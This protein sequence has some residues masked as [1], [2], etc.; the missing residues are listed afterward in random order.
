MTNASHSAKGRGLKISEI[1]R[2]LSD[3]GLI[4][5]EG[6][7]SVSVEVS[8]ICTDSRK[9]KRGDVF[10]A[11]KGES[12]DSHTTIPSLLQKD[13]KPALVIYS[14]GQFT[15]HFTNDCSSLRVSDTRLAWSLLCALECEFAKTNLEFYGVTGTNGKTS[16]VF[17]LNHFLKAQGKKVLTIGTLGFD[18]DGETQETKHTTPDP[19]ELFAAI[20]KAHAASFDVV[21]MEVSSHAIAQSKLGPI[22]FDKVLFTSF[23]RDHLDFHKSM[24]DYFCQKWRLFTDL[25]KRSARKVVHESILPW[26][27]KYCR[28]HG[29]DLVIYGEKSSSHP[30]YLQKLEKNLDAS[31]F[32]LKVAEQEYTLSTNLVGDFLLANTV[33]CLALI[34]D[35]NAQQFDKIENL[36]TIP[37]RLDRVHHKSLKAPVF[38]DYAHTPDAL[39]TCLRTLRPLTKGRLIVVF[40]CGGDRDRGKRPMMG[41]AAALFADLLI[42]T[43]DNPRTEDPSKIILDIVEGFDRDSIDF[44]VEVNRSKAIAV[45]V[46]KADESDCILIAGK[47]H[48]DYQ[49][50]GTSKRYFSDHKEVLKNCQ[51]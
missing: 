47:G 5:D 44:E 36:P 42:V 25:V 40:G 28:N 11:I 15:R 37:G 31:R 12:F 43:S 7:V 18:F 13:V 17:I 6:I 1:R 4:I 22:R 38:V 8:E 32:K 26:I 20:R 49:I 21:V 46:S 39:E 2:C 9:I 27:E 29:L 16:S 45:A 10:I 34:N 19:P 33:G 41:K 23:S 30:W 50:V 48:E 14:D 35:L 3:A 51:S 24:E